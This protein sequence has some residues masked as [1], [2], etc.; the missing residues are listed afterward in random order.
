MVIPDAGDP[1]LE[2]VLS[3]NR[4]R[5]CLFVHL[6]SKPWV[7]LSSAHR[8]RMDAVKQRLSYGGLFPAIWESRLSFKQHK[9]VIFHHLE[10]LL[11]HRQFPA[12]SPEFDSARLRQGLRIFTFQTSFQNH[13]LRPTSRR[14]KRFYIVCRRYQKI[15]CS[16]Y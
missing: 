8:S 9:T 16:K 2:S 1:R 10:G 7:P 13:I 6:H 11:K 15:E 5:T 4:S 14:V 12:L 3:G